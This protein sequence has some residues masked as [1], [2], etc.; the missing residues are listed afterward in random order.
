MQLFYGK[1]HFFVSWFT[2]M[3][4][5][6]RTVK[7]TV[8]SRSTDTRT[9]RPARCNPIGCTPVT[10]PLTFSHSYLPLHGYYYCTTPHLP[11][12]VTPWR[13]TLS[14]RLFGKLSNLVGSDRDGAG[15]VNQRCRTDGSACRGIAQWSDLMLRTMYL[16][17]KYRHLDKHLTT[18]SEHGNT[19]FDV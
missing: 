14:T 9:S 2:A 6:V 1:A 7:N 3:P 11:F 13:T 4:L 10:P 19:C 12:H 18:C 17:S 8:T 16:W 15:R 5:S